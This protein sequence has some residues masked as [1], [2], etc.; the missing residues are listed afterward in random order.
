MGKVTGILAKFLLLLSLTL[1]GGSQ[2][3]E[4][5]ITGVRICPHDPAQLYIPAGEFTMGST[6]EEREYAYR[7]DKQVTRSYG[8][9]EKE[10]RKKAKTGSFCIDQYPI[11]NGKYKT[12]LDENGGKEPTISPESYQR[13]GFLVHPYG[14]VKEFL[15]REGSFLPDRKNHPVVLVSLKDAMSYCSWMGKKK[16]R[17]YRLPTEEEWEKAARGPEGLIFP[18]GNEWNPDT[19]NSGNRYGSTTPVSTFPLG[20]SVYGVYDM[21]GDL[22]EWTSTSWEKKSPDKQG[23]KFVLKGCSWD[24]LPGTCRAAMRHGRPGKSRHILIGFRCISEVSR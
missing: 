14:K 23:E 1:F 10:T 11:T 19:L 18:W 24:D 2:R 7:L 22:F 4:G 5:T 21:V 20:R 13:Q 6:R 16:G 3:A 8:W 12:F 17:N 15:W 9:Y